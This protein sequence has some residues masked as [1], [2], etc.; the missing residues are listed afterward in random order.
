[1]PSPLQPFWHVIAVT[2]EYSREFSQT[3]KGRVVIVLT[4][5]RT[6]K[7]CLLSCHGLNYLLEKNDLFTSKF[8]SPNNLLNTFPKGN[9]PI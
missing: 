6:N 2:N 8:I 7:A 1:M 4:I 9:M 5:F 3:S